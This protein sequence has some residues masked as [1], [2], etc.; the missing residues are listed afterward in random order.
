MV[1]AGGRK[2][3]MRIHAD[4]DEISAKDI[5]LKAVRVWRP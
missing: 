5:V 1:K 3:Q 2:A 4:I